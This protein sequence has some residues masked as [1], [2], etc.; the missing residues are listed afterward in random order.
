[1]R[2]LRGWFRDTLPTFLGRHRWSLLR[3][4][5]DHYESTI[6][7]L[8]NLYPDLSP[9]G[10]VIVD[11]YGG[12]AQCQQAVDDFRAANG[13]DEEL[14]TIDWTGMWWR[15]LQEGPKPRRRRLRTGGRGV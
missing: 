13:I 1:V 15:R 2:F 9:G 14:H 10:F 3:L 7:A 5:G 12:V 6:L 11:D 4:D 8:E